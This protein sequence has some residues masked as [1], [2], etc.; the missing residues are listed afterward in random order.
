MVFP[1]G[2]VY[3]EGCEA[4]GYIG[5]ESR[6]DLKLALLTQGERWCLC[7]YLESQIVTTYLPWQDAANSSALAQAKY[8][9]AVPASPVPA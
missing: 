2:E 7:A 6:P 4:L 5:L 1:A 9:R 3:R 8:R